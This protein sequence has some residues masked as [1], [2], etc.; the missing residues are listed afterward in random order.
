MEARYATRSKLQATSLLQTAKS[1]H[2]V[3]RRLQ[4]AVDAARAAIVRRLEKDV[5]LPAARCNAASALTF[6]RAVDARGDT[7]AKQDDEERLQWT[8]CNS[9]ERGWHKQKLVSTSVVLS[10]EGELLSLDHTP[11]ALA[12]AHATARPASLGR[13]VAGVSTCRVMRESDIRD[14]YFWPSGFSDGGTRRHFGCVLILYPITSSPFI[15]ACSEE[16]SNFITIVNRGDDLGGTMHLY[17]QKMPG[18]S[19]AHEV[20]GMEIVL[21]TQSLEDLSSFRHAV[22]EWTVSIPCRTESEP[23]SRTTSIRMDEN[24]CGARNESGGCKNSDGSHFSSQ[25]V[26]PNIQM[27][28]PEALETISCRRLSSKC[29]RSRYQL[30]TVQ[31]SASDRDTSVP[32]HFL[33]IVSDSNSHG[34]RD[35]EGRKSNCIN[36]CDTSSSCSECNLDLI[37]RTPETHR[38]AAAAA[39]AELAIALREAVLARQTAELAGREFLQLFL[40]LKQQQLLLYPVLLAVPRRSWTLV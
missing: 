40:Q 39:R 18:A 16:G 15:P 13:L 37:V 19:V 3:P 28:A 34:N 7:E 25:N 1:S 12:N 2:R 10:M 17:D 5:L 33:E 32:Q 38:D 23:I 9:K 21:L 6:L 36:D 4:G 20:A 14:S 11:A 24:F 27:F 29:S 35:K 31:A 8:G 30:S 22:Q 26:Q